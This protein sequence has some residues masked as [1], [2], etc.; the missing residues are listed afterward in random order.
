MKYNMK[1]VETVYNGTTFRSRLEANWAACFDIYRWQWT[2]EPFDLDG[3][4]PDFLLKSEDSERPDVLVEVVERLQ[5]VAVD[6][7]RVRVVVCH[8]AGQ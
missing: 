2:Y 7:L 1:S 5:L 8:L 6:R 4:S 3:W